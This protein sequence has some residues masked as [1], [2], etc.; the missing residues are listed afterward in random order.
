MAR[1]SLFLRAALVAALAFGTMAL[2]GCSSNH[3]ITKTGEACA[4]CHSDGRAAVEGA[5]SAA[6]T[7]TG[8]A[9]AVESSADEVYLCTASVAEDG[10]VIPAQMRKL[11]ADELG[12]VTVSEGGLYALCTGDIAGP[13]SVVLVHAAEDGPADAAVKL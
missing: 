2:A 7:E 13:S 10:T 11:S 4:S 9:F 1:H 3:P 5:G 12:T 8:L 6:V